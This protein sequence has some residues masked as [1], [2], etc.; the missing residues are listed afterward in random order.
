MKRK[1]NLTLLL[2]SALRSIIG[3]PALT[4][5]IKGIFTAGVIKSSRYASAKL[6]KWIKAK[7]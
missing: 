3:K 6:T 7:K 4:Q 5:S 2:L 1:M